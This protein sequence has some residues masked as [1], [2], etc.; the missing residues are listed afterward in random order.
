MKR[1]GHAVGREEI[2]SCQQLYLI[3]MTIVEG[4][5]EKRQIRRDREW[6]RWDVV[7]NDLN[8]IQGLPEPASIYFT[9]PAAYGVNIHDS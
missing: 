9:T 8:T 2:S 7:D 6:P 3:I 5:R 4:Q 1:R